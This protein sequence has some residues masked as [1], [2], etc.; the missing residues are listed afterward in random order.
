MLLYERAKYGILIMKK[1]IIFNNGS[2][3]AVLRLSVIRQSSC[4]MLS[5]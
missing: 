1:Y 5:E 3:I 4:V 2:A